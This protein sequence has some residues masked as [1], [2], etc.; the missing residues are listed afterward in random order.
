MKRIVP[1]KTQMEA[2]L[3][4]GLSQAQIARQYEEDTGI[5]VSRAAI[6]MAINRYGLSSNKPSFRYEDLLPWHLKPEHTMHT[7]ARLLRLEARRRRGLPLSET[8]LKWLDS[9]LK[10]MREQNAV[11]TYNPDTEDG[12]FWVERTAEDN[13]IIRRP[14]A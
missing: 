2:Y 4:A 11:V 12:F 7:E 6:G 14:A 3:R 1:D 5:R 9:W 8:D 13:D 10:E